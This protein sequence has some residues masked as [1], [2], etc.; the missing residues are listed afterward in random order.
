MAPVRQASPTDAPLL[1]R[2]LHDFNTEFEDPSPG[3]DALSERVTQFINDGVKTYLLGGD[4]PDG[5]AQIDFIPSIW[6]EGPVAHL[7]ELYV[8]PSKRG[9]GIGKALMV[10]MLE[11]ARERGAAGA[12]VVTGE[13]DTEARGLYESFG[14][15]NEIEGPQSS[16]S[17]FY[18]LDF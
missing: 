13:D 1:A 17:L 5:F 15:A 11:L 7:D 9:R 12:E 2:M 4:G 8:V 16:R 6:S 14:F 3:I 10:G 18:E